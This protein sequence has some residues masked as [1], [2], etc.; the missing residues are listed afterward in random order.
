MLYYIVH[1]V[2]L[3]DILIGDY[4]AS[5]NGILRMYFLDVGISEERI[6]M[7]ILE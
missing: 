4:R 2:D 3:A 1:F 7:I 6:R 5:M